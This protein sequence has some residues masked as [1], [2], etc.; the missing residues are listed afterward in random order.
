MAVSV[1]TLGFDVD[2]AT[3]FPNNVYDPAASTVGIVNAIRL[4]N[5]TASAVTASIK[6]YPAGVSGDAIWILQDVSIPANRSY[7]GRGLLVLEAGDE[8]QIIESSAVGSSL[9]ALVTGIEHDA[10]GSP[11]SREKIQTIDNSAYETLMTASSSNQ[12]INDMQVINFHASSTA[13]LNVQWI[14]GGNTIQL[15]DD[16]SLE[17][18]ELWNY[19]GTLD[20]TSGDVIKMKSSVASALDCWASVTEQT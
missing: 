12:T 2:V 11:A 13:T 7:W 5:K 3:A 8:L 16:Y 19:I 10:T 6:I 9:D 1:E 18:G 14:R 15:V 17:P 20:L 4:T